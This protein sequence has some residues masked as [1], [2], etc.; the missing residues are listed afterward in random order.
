[1]AMQTSDPPTVSLA[2]LCCVVD[3]PLTWDNFSCA[4]HRRDPAD[5][6][7]NDHPTIFR[8]LNIASERRLNL[9]PAIIAANAE[10][11]IYRYKMWKLKPG[12]ACVA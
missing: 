6:W 5:L 4:A 11:T 9:N 1:M 7:F 10:T 8:S 2:H 3:I 12:A